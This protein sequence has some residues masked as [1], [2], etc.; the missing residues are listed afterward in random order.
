M[1][2][3]WMTIAV[4]WAFACCT[5]V[6]A[7]TGIGT[8]KTVK[9]EVHIERGQK[10]VPVVPGTAVMIKD[11]LQTGKD[12]SVGIIFKDNA[13]LSL[14]ENSRLAVDAFLFDPALDRT[15]FVADMLKG[16]MT[17]LTGII[18]RLNPE[19]VKIQTPAATIGI[20]GTHLAVNVED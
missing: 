9:G 2:T 5:T 7:G 14:G 12:G 3:R 1:R 16:T 18:G 13:V 10:M 8:V 15:G 17:Y 4:I 19:S 20:R 6:L 11:V